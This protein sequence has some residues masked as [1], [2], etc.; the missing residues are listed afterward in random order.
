MA[1]ATATLLWVE[2]L[3]KATNEV[4]AAWACEASA[5]S[6]SNT[7]DQVA[8]FFAAVLFVLVVVPLLIILYFVSKFSRIH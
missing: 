1:C 2:L 6:E 4:A 3:G 5:N 8:L 7:S